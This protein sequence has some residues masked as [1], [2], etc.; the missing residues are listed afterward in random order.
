M[1]N[2]PLVIGILLTLAGLAMLALARFAG[3][4]LLVSAV[5]ILGALI[6]GLGVILIAFP[7]IK[8]VYGELTKMF[9]LA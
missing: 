7:V 4:A 3:W 6:L 1:M 9:G 2:N 5:K 8:Y